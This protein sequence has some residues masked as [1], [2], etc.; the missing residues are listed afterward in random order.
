MKE[1]RSFTATLCA[2]V[3]SSLQSHRG[4]SRHTAPRGTPGTEDAMEEVAHTVVVGSCSSPR[5][6]CSLSGPD[7]GPIPAPG[8]SPDTWQELCLGHLPS[9]TEARST[10][11]ALPNPLGPRILTQPVLVTHPPGS[12]MV[13]CCWCLSASGFSPRCPDANRWPGLPVI[14]DGPIWHLLCSSCL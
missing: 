10:L 11:A 6:P 12:Q 4:M 13:S 8:L 1:I 14:H 3:F 5:S 9:R 2:S 7:T